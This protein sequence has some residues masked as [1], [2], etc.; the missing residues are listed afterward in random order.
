[1]KRSSEKPVMF[2]YDTHFSVS[3]WPTSLDQSILVGDPGGNCGHISLPKAS[4]NM[5]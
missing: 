3:N 4:L 1:M 5:A 2:L